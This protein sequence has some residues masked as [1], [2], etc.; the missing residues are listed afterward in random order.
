VL[1][2]YIYFEGLAIG[3]GNKLDVV[4]EKYRGIKDLPTV[5]AL[6]NYKNGLTAV[7]V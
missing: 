1:R 6:S 7:Y 2:I 4:Y 5:C 3:F